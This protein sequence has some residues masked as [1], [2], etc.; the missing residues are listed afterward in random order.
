MFKVLKKLKL[1]KKISSEQYVNNSD[2]F[3]MTFVI[4]LSRWTSLL[5]SVISIPMTIQ[6]LSGPPQIRCINHTLSSLVLNSLP[7]P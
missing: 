3:A 6:L 4:A 7:D 2:G 5:L 1:G